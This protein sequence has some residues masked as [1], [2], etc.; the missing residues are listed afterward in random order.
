MDTMTG[1]VS[2]VK[3]DGKALCIDETWYSSWDPISG[4]NKGD[5]V[6][7][8]Y[9]QKGRYN[10][11]KGKVRVTGSSPS[12]GSPQRATSNNYNLGVELGHAS[13]LAMRM[14]E[15]NNASAS[16]APAVGSEEYYKQFMMYTENMYEVMKRI[17]KVKEQQLEKEELATHKSDTPDVEGDDE[18]I[19]G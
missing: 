8:N 1:V 13:N 18:D 4:V 16:A 14:M 7:F 6:M 3:R 17:R 9:Q 11:I 10:N 5:N 19:F 2:A 12:A 15:Q